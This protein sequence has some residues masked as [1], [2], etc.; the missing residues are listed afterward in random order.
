MVPLRLVVGKQQKDSGQTLD[1]DEVEMPRLL[2]VNVGLPRDVK[3]NGN[4]VRTS[5]WKSPVDGR[6]MVRKLDIDG[7][8]QADLAGH[9]GEHRA[10]FVYQMDSYHYWERFLGRSDFTF[11]QFGENFTVEGLLDSEVCIGD[12]YRIGGAIFEVTQ[13][14]VTCYRVGIRMN[15]PRMPALLV[16]QHRPGFYFR[17]LQE[18]EVGAGDDIAKITDGPERMSV[19]EVDA[20]LYLP[21]QSSEQLQ[22]A[23]RIPA[24]SKGWRSSFQAMLQQDLSSKT[25]AGNP[26]LANEEQA[27]A[28]PG[29]RQMRVAI[30]HKESESVTSFVLA[31][32]EGQPLPVFQA[33]QFVVLRL[34]VDPGKP[35]VLRSYSLSDLP[36]ADH[37]R[38]SVKSEL[39]GIASS[40]LCHRARAGDVLEV[41]APRGSF[42]LRSSQSPVVLLSAGVGAT[43][44]ISMLHSLAAEK[45]Q[46]EI[47]WIYGA[48]N[49]ADHPFAEESRS[50]L[51]QLSRGREF[52]V[53]S[54][55]AATD[56]AGADFDA[57]GHIDTAL[58]ER[59]GVPQDS[60]F[61]LCGPPSFLQSMRDGLGNWGVLAENV[62]TEIF[63]SLEAITPGMAQGVHTPHLPQGPPGSGPPVSFARSGIT[64]AWDRKFASLLELAEACDVPVRWSCRAGV[65]HTC[66]TGLIGGSTIYNPEP[67]ERPAPGNVLICCSQPNA[68]VSLDL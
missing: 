28:W 64:A 18:G 32:I 40:F 41:S 34:L 26:G 66:L 2:S 21:G 14:R 25:T 24:L 5:V 8:A 48:R 43:P 65:C 23:L 13:P 3:W 62:H 11:G 56:R 49:R 47:W 50:L 52:I 67:L 35:P 27:P 7:D 22:R 16:A 68:G 44:V 15:E 63:G 9:G 46:R 59:I 36:A 54:R 12:R 33:G 53:Y 61:Y 6:R 55:P 29:F 60:D 10:V 39:R 19:A 30:I 45:S 17:V 58:L 31:P 20:L 38:I 1:F 51:Q 37:F 57:P 4:T 42:T